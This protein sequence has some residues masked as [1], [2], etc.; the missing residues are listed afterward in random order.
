MK[1]RCLNCMK[2]FSIPEGQESNKFACPFCDYIEGTAPKEITYLYPGTLLQNRYIIGTTLG[3][4]G[5]GITYKAWDT[6]LDMVVAIKEYYPAGMV[7]RVPGDPNLIV[8]GG[9][10]QRKARILSTLKIILKQTIRHI[11]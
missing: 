3:A 10:H 7:Q 1:R 8:Y 11:L 6:T 4:G 5:F 2:E 9:R